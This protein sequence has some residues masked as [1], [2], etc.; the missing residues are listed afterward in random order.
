[1]DV[2]AEELI[3]GTRRFELVIDVGPTWNDLSLEDDVGRA[4]V[5]VDSDVMT[6]A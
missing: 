2:T 6:D 3:A 5:L 4:L 1:M